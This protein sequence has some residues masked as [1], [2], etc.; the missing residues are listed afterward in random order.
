VQVPTFFTNQT[1][2]YEWF[3]TSMVLFRIDKC[4]TSSA[5]SVQLFV[6]DGDELI[7]G[8]SGSVLSAGVGDGSLVIN[9]V[10]GGGTVAVSGGAA[11]SRSR[12][13]TT[14]ESL[15]SEVVSVWIFSGMTVGD[16]V[17]ALVI[18]IATILMAIPS[19]E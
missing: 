11:F 16:C 18:R 1:F 7:D 17:H 6:G 12:N 5:S 9:E 14:S 19:L 8:S 4:L 3:E 2:P 10:E 15:L 13:F